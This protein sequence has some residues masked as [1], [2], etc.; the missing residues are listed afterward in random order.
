MAD[1]GGRPIL[2]HVVRRVGTCQRADE[3]WVATTERPEDDVLVALAERLGAGVF[4]GSES[5]VLARYVGAAKAAKAEACVR[6]TADCP[7]IDPE[8]VDR[9]IDSFLKAPGGIDYASN[10][11]KPSFPRGL[12]TEVF[13][14]EALGIAHLEAATSFDRSHVTTFLYRHPQRFRLLGVENDEDLSAW[15]WTVD[16][17]DDLRFVREVVAA[18]GPDEGVGFREVRDLLRQR[19]ELLSINAH[20]V[21]KRIEEG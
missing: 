14:V 10:R 12:D 15:R 3:V 1:L 11:L 6:V 8:I 21:Q 17:P 5:D 18:L 19:P 4:R 9:V 13:T 20:V 7:L 16:E 2:E